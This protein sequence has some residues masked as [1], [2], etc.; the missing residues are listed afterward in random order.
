MFVPL[1]SS[2]VQGTARW[3]LFR[4][5][6]TTNHSPSNF[7]LSVLLKRPE[8]LLFPFYVYPSLWVP[9]FS[10]ESPNDD[11]PYENT[12][13]RDE[14][15]FFLE[16]DFWELK[17]KMWDKEEHLLFIHWTTIQPHL[18][19]T[20]WV[21]EWETLDRQMSLERSKSLGTS[22]YR[23]SVKFKVQFLYKLLILKFDV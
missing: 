6:H 22:C 7:H 5:T 11:N 10:F 19:C 23:I 3:N 14:K 8:W 2:D 18:I 1:G 21:R 17:D 12:G 9:G 20:Q 15:Y 13:S 16:K 4:E